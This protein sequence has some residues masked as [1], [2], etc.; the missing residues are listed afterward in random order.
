MSVVGVMWKMP[1]KPFKRSA[2]WNSE[3]EAEPL[4]LPISFWEFSAQTCQIDQLVVKLA[5][6]KMPQ[7]KYFK[8]VHSIISG[9]RVLD[10][11]RRL[12]GRGSGPSL[13]HVRLHAETGSVARRCCLLHAT[14][15]SSKQMMGCGLWHALSPRT[16]RAASS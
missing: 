6:S 11:T 4:V 1:T 16:R 15:Q 8:L 12:D 7:V 5:P 3:R 13:D 14:H 2:V 9:V 10:Y